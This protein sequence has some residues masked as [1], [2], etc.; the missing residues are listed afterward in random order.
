M[1]RKPVPNYK[2]LVTAIRG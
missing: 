1:K 2:R